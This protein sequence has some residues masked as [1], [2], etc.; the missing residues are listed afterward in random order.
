MPLPKIY[1]LEYAMI[2]MLTW[3]N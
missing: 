2:I 3:R 1:I